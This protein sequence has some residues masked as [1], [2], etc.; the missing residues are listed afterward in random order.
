MILPKSCWLA[1]LPQHLTSL[2]ARVS[3]LRHEGRR[4]SKPTGCRLQTIRVAVEETVGCTEQKTRV[5]VVALAILLR[6]G[7]GI[8]QIRLHSSEETMT[9]VN[10][11]AGGLWQ[12]AYPHS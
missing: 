7:V 9:Q 11:R 3:A 6:Q 1:T 5:P 2:W 12:S 10:H 4:T 8:S